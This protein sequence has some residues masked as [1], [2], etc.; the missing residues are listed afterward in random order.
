MIGLD[1]S[2][3]PSSPIEP[4]S[5]SRLPPSAYSSGPRPR[6][7]SRGQLTRPPSVAASLASIDDLGSSSRISAAAFR[8][9]IRRPSE[10]AALAVDDDDDDVPLG[11]INRPRQMSRNQSA[12]SLSSLQEATRQKQG[13]DEATGMP[14]ALVVDVAGSTPSS[15]QHDLASRATPSPRPSSSTRPSPSPSPGPGYPVK[16]VTPGGRFVVKGVTSSRDVRPGFDRQTSSGQASSYS[17]PRSASQSPSPSL[18]RLAAAAPIL[19][20]TEII[21]SPTEMEHQ[22]SHSAVSSHAPKHT[23][24]TS[25]FEVKDERH[26]EDHVIRLND[27]PVRESPI[28]PAPPVGP[29]SLPE[30]GNTSPSLNDLPLPPDLMPDTPPKS[31][32]ALAE[33]G[34]TSTSPGKA[35][36]ISLLEEPLRAISGLWSPSSRDTGP[37]ATA[38][39]GPHLPDLSRSVMD[40][41]AVLQ[42]VARQEELPEPPVKS[43]LFD[44]TPSISPVT[45]R[46]PLSVRLA[47]AAELSAQARSVNPSAS[48]IKDQVKPQE[49]WMPPDLSPTTLTHFVDQQESKVSQLAPKVEDPPAPVENEETEIVSSFVRARPAMRQRTSSNKAEPKVAVSPVASAAPLSVEPESPQSSFRPPPPTRSRS[50]LANGRNADAESSE[51][52][53]ESDTSIKAEPTQSSTSRKHPMGPRQ[54]AVSVSKPDDDSSSEEESLAVLRARASRSSLA[55]HKIPSHPSPASPPVISLPD[56]PLL[57]GSSLPGGRN[58]MPASAPDSPRKTVR[59][60]APHGRGVR[61]ASSSVPPVKSPLGQD[62]RLPRPDIGG[63]GSPASSSQS[64]TSESQVQGPMTPRD[65]ASLRRDSLAETTQP[66]VGLLKAVT[67]KL[68]C[69]GGLTRLESDGNLTSRNRATLT[70][71]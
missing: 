20:E 71:R 46:S 14:G 56:S 44:G 1:M 17:I 36:R 35:R 59:S 8:K 48:A 32:K 40:Q 52:D 54:R 15:V 12:L 60:L 61:H 68:T 25:W 58:A 6:A 28:R 26:N 65:A 19:D 64:A 45:D 18:G 67:V 11:M 53:T 39:P 10:G 69:R 38:R 66:Q 51:S 30:R 37:D 42:A 62:T 7:P 47:K 50:S 9:G 3:N 41:S 2:H 27:S 55:L 63:T 49:N 22:T 23:R 4:S 21:Q 70:T 13:Q 34:A 5:P 57:T 31:D 33:D 24:T 16:R 43:V 29:I